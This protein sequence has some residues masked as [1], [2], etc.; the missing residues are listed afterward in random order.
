M[1]KRPSSAYLKRLGENIRRLRTKK[2]LSLRELSASCTIDHSDISKIENG[3]VNIT[4]LTLIELA[5][6][7]EV[8][9][10]EIIDFEIELE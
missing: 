8:N 3:A 10:G 5:K 6:A 9:P 7:L 4:F 2:G 1:A